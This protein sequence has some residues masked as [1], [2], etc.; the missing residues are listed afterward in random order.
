MNSYN[1]RS[2]TSAAITALADIQAN[3]LVIDDGAT[4][5]SGKNLH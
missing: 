2:F 3:R 5:A 1:R 4:Y